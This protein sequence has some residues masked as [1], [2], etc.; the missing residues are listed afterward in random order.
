MCGVVVYFIVHHQDAGDIPSLPET[1][2]I[3]SKDQKEIEEVVQNFMKDNSTWGVVEDKLVSKDISFQKTMIMKNRPESYEMFLG[4]TDTYLVTRAKYISKHSAL[5]YEDSVTREWSDSFER[6]SLVN[7]TNNSSAV[8]IP[9]KG[10]VVKIGGKNYPVVS[11]KASFS[12]T[13]KRRLQMVNDSSW[14]GSFE[15]Q[16]KVFSGKAD[17]NV[18]KEKDGW[19]VYSMSNVSHPFVFSTW[20]DNGEDRPDQFDFTKVGTIKGGEK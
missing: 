17:V 15:V 11:T 1:V 10:S 6:D 12:V 9:E 19:K 14:D 18:V 16:Q 8:S 5:W 7:Y 2:D 3:S 13:E 4:K 20:D